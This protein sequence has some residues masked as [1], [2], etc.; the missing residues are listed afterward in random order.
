M[1]DALAGALG[2]RLVRADHIGVRIGP[3]WVQRFRYFDRILERIESV[4]G[5]VVECGVAG[6]QSLAMFA[7]LMRARGDTRSLWGFD[8][9]TGLPDPTSEDLASD[10]TRAVGGLFGWAGQSLVRSE[11]KSHGFEDAE[12][13]ELVTL[14]KGDFRDT[15]DT[16]A[17]GPIAVLHLD[18][19]L[20]D[21]Y[22]V[23]LA[24]LWRFVAIGGVVAFDEYEDT[25]AWPGARKAV[26]EFIADQRAEVEL[27][28]DEDAMKTFAIRR[29]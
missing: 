3:E 13:S 16:Y 11:L 15:L 21:S 20:Y 17:G 4:D 10:S 7:S 12:I 27:V 14:V 23:A 25:V 1:N 28:H 29:G 8:S 18:V 19:D 5:T 22:R 24:S 6:G 9:W 26:D 2:V